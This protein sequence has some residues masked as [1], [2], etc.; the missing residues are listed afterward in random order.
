M[1]A[2]I[3]GQGEMKGVY[4]EHNVLFISACKTSG[5]PLPPQVR[6]ISPACGLCDAD[7]RLS[8]CSVLGLAFCQIFE[9]LGETEIDLHTGS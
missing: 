3:L 1:A 8:V 2:Q 7:A 9:K 4:F 6:P 5:E